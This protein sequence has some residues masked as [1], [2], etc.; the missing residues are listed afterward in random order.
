MWVGIR[1]LPSPV[2]HCTFLNLQTKKTKGEDEDFLDK[3]TV[4]CKDKSDLYQDRLSNP[5]IFIFFEF[6]VLD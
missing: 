3:L 1:N 4:Q 5:G 6:L 2:K